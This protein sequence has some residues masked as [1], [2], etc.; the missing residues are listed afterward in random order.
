MNV[1][2][3]EDA[4]DIP[5]LEIELHDDGEHWIIS[6]T[7]PCHG[8]IARCE[9][10]IPRNPSPIEIEMTRDAIERWTDEVDMYGWANLTGNLPN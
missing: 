1:T 6:R 5:D 4:L 10:V 2:A 9:I 8:E 3:L 7:M